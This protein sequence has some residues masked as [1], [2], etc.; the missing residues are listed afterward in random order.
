MCREALDEAAPSYPILNNICIYVAHDCTIYLQDVIELCTKSLPHKKTEISG[1][2]KPTDKPS[3]KLIPNNN[4]HKDE[5][6]Q[7]MLT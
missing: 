6:E 4:N 3:E 7:G 2:D 1:Q 5:Q